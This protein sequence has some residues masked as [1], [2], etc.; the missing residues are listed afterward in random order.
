VHV[1]AALL[2]RFYQYLDG[3]AFGC[4]LG[5]AVAEES[6]LE[7]GDWFTRHGATSITLCDTAGQASPVEV[8]R[9]CD[10]L[11]ERWKELTLRLQFRNVHGLAL[12]NVLA[13]LS[14][15]INEYQATL[16]GINSEDDNAG[17][18]LCL[19]D[20]VHMLHAMGCRTGLNPGELTSCSE[21]MEKLLWKPMPSC[22]RRA[23]H[24]WLND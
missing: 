17:G 21:R 6:I 14:A 22:K 3:T 18:M 4:P 5:G 2:P 15:G 9:L 1:L 19:E 11:V 10:G 24:P 16:G 23:V 13:G 8:E 12:P 20:L 7:I